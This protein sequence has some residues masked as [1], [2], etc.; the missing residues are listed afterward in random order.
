M[1]NSTT[2]VALETLT[3]GLPV[4][5][6][7]TSGRTIEGYVHST[8]QYSHTGFHA[9]ISAGEK[10]FDLHHFVKRGG[11][12]TESVGCMYFGRKVSN[13]GTVAT[14]EEITPCT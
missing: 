9:M 10:A 7:L 1:T 12:L 14:I 5:V 2:A 6:T 13:V 3:A 4:R 8:A 11:G